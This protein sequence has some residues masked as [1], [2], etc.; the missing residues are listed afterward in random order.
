MKR[1]TLYSIIILVVLAIAAY[2]ALN[3][4]GEVS[5]TRSSGTMLVHYD[6]TSVDKLEFISPTGSV[7]LERLAGVWMLT[8]PVRY[9]ADETAVASAVGKGRTIEYTSLVSTN[10][11]KQRLFQVDSAGTLVKVYEKGV[12]TAAFHIGK[13]SSSFTETYV[14]LEGSNDVRL[15]NEVLSS[16]FVKQPKEWRDKTIFKIDEGKIK[17][18]KQK[19]D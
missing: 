16:Y 13:A 1:N 12:R 19:H 18:V 14:R 8:S 7:V 11:E 4:E 10:P 5:S 2:L 9:K 3:R 15:A 6:S 17:N